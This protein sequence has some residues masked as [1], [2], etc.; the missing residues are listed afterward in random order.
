MS[1]EKDSDD[2]TEEPTAKRLED[3]RKKGQVPRSADL[4]AAAVSIAAAGAIDSFGT[5]AASELAN[6]VPSTCHQL[7]PT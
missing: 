1:E 6:D 2:R 4:S 5:K 3:A 7:A